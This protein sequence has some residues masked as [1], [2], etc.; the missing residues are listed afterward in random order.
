MQSSPCSKGMR[1]IFEAAYFGELA[2]DGEVN[3]T[4]SQG[5]PLP[6]WEDLE[7]QEPRL[8]NS[9]YTSTGRSGRSGQSRPGNKRTSRED[10]PL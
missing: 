5:V 1:P 9:A 4:R 3:P 10:T 8:D 7:D 2:K 6:I